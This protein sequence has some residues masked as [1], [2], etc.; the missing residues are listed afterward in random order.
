MLFFA[1][2]TS[3]RFCSGETGDGWS[4]RKEVKVVEDVGMARGSDGRETSGVY[5][6]IQGGECARGNVERLLKGLGEDGTSEK[7]SEDLMEQF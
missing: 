1:S 4:E 3:A 6:V 7:V 5:S 2:A